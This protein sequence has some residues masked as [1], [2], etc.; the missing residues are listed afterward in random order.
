ML[1]IEG[2]P[3]V[4]DIMPCTVDREEQEAEIVAVGPLLLEARIRAKDLDIDQSYVPT[5]RFGAAEMPI[6]INRDGSAMTALIR[7]R[8]R[9]G[10]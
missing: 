4:G 1:Q 7:R 3:W 8:A 5:D 10:R 9:A 2:E 6:H